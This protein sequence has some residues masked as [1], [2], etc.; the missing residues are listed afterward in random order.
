[1]LSIFMTIAD[2]GERRLAEELYLAY[3]GKMYGIAYSILRN[4]EDAEDAV[5][6]SVYKIVNNIA[7]FSGATRNETE[8]LIVIIT[9]NTAINRYNSNRRRSVLPLDADRADIPD[10][11]PTPAEMFGDN[12][13]Y[14]ALV[15]KIRSLE[16]IYRDVLV[17]KY[18][19]GCDNATVASLTGVAETTVRVRLMRAR[20]QLAAK[21]SG[22]ETNGK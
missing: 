10:S 16:P 7:R 15:A 12:E 21:L 19:R 13:D 22:G 18:L 11:D 9:R 14:E 6:D 2:D 17:L 8:S 4:R 3:R 5:M 20:A 1:M